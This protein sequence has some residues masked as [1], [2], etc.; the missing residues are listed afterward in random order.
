MLTARDVNGS[1]WRWIVLLL[2]AA[3]GT[4]EPGSA[5]FVSSVGQA[6]SANSA[7][8]SG[9][10]SPPGAGRAS[11]PQAGA[12]PVAGVPAAV[13]GRA[14]SAG[15]AGAAGSAAISDEDA[16]TPDA[17][18]AD[19]GSS[20]APASRS[21]GPGDWKAGDYPP[22]LTM[23][24]FL[25]ITGLPNQ[26]GVA[27]QYKVHV[28]PLYDPNV[29]M[30]VVF[31]FHGLGQDAL[32]FCINGAGMPAKAD[33]EGFIL[34]MPNGYA[35]SWNGGTCCGDA[36]AQKLDE[37]G[38]VRAVFAEV[39]KHLN[40]DLTR[41][42]A[43]GLSNGGYMS[44]RLACE[45]ADVFVAVAPGAGAIGSADI[46][47]GTQAES[48]IA[49]CNAKGVSVLAIHGTDDGLVAYSAHKPSLDRIAEQNGCMLTTKPAAQP[50]SMG[51]TTCTSYEGCPAGVDVTGCTVQ[52][53]GHVWF[54]SPNC[55]TGVDAA[56]AIVGANSTNIT[57]TDVIWEFFRNHSRP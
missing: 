26:A 48:D 6:G 56:C 9:S 10:A 12:A 27:R 17:S 50:A 47:G 38:F 7:G 25:E 37:I 13:S 49:A 57:N 31:C 55:G 32:L 54:G 44:F 39:G 24:N 2:C 45:A 42:Y 46:G 14:G 4:R 33:K 28:P 19:S 5:P 30:P 3:C 15:N 8:T 36:A 41:V 29:P 16:G 53:G 43:T 34:V 11:N 51:D 40:I 22:E 20:G 1:N 23:P 18:A 52:G 35:N 21:T